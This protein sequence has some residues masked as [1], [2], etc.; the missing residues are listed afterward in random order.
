MKVMKKQSHTPIKYTDEHESNSFYSIPFAVFR[1]CDPGLCTGSKNSKR[2][3]YYSRRWRGDPRCKHYHQGDEG[4]FRKAGNAADF[5]IVHTYYT[6]Y[7]E[8]SPAHVILNSAATETASMINWLRTSTSRA[9]TDMKPMALTEW[10]IFAI[11]SKQSCSFVNGMHAAMVLGELAKNQ[12]GMS[13]RWDFANGYDNGDDHGI[14][15]NG[16]E[17]GVPKWNP[18]P[19]FFYMYY[20]QRFFGDH[21][22]TSSTSGSWDILSFASRFASG[23]LGIVV[24]NKN[25][26]AKTVKLVMPEFGY[27]DQY[28]LYSLTG[29]TDNGEFSQVVNVNGQGADNATGGPINNLDSIRAWS[30]II[31]RS[32]VFESPGRS[33]QYILIEDGDKTF[34]GIHSFEYENPVKIFPNPS[35]GEFICELPPGATN[36]EVT[37]LHGKMIFVADLEGEKRTFRFVLDQVSGLFITRIHSKTGVYINRLLIQ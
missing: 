2:N 29:G 33:V 26:G 12:Y 8:N 4:F 18:R 22:V 35:R 19:A 3:S 15:N 24:V 17:P 28:Y 13:S 11:G 20:F 16:D 10:N 32:I 7:D 1:H 37:D 6:P 25:T 34:T 27:G 23:E 36:I 21:L 31:D 30:N 9:G 5:F 14:F